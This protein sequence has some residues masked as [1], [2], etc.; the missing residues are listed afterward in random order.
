MPTIL[1]EPKEVGFNQEI[2]FNCDKFEQKVNPLLEKL[3]NPDKKD[4]ALMFKYTLNKAE[5]PTPFKGEHYDHKI[6]DFRVVLSKDVLGAGCTTAE[7]KV[8]AFK[9]GQLPSFVAVKTYKMVPGKEIIKVEEQQAMINRPD[10]KIEKVN[11]G[12]DL[13][14]NDMF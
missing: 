10:Q 13:N 14:L 2:R 4:G 7:I 11:P 1:P 3:Q 6:P 12:D 9:M 8:I 5:I